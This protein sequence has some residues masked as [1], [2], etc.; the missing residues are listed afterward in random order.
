MGCPDE[1]IE[2][3][4]DQ[5]QEQYEQLL[6][7][8]QEAMQEHQ[9]LVWPEN[10]EAVQ[11]FLALSMD[12]IKPNAMGGG[13][14]LPTTEI[15]A[16]MRISGTQNHHHCWNQL[17]IMKGHAAAILMQQFIEASNAN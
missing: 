14:R 1:E 16:A 5:E 3:Q 4:I 9:V 17:Q 2:R 10:W 13:Y 11:L 15:E 6:T 12:W 7:D 8:W